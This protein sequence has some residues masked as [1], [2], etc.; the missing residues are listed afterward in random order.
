MIKKLCLLGYFLVG[1]W[2]L[3]NNAGI[4]YVSELEMT[5]EK[6][7]RDVLEVNL[8]GMINLNQNISTSDKKGARSNRQYVISYR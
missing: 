6:V 8:M 5:S 7:F 1:L 2:G 4:W 3:V